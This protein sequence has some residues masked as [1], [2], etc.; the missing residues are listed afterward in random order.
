MPDSGLALMV[1]KLLLA[2]PFLLSAVAK[3]RDFAGAT[4]EVR[5]LG[6]PLPAVAAAATI[7]AQAFGSALLLLGGT[8]DW[9]GAAILAGFTIAAT[10]LAHRFWAA[11]A[12]QRMPQLMTFLEHAAI[13]GGLGFIIWLRTLA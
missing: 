11:P 1:L 5:A 7:A 3:S 13:V 2:S 9:L 8:W 4:A 6:L 10:L 12:G